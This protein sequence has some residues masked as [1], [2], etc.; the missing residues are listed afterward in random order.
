M[1]KTYRVLIVEDESATIELYQNA[2]THVQQQSDT[3]EFQIETAKDCPTAYDNICKAINGIPYDLVFLDISLPSSNGH[4]IKS[5]EDLGVLIRKKM[6][7]TRIIVITHH[8]E[9]FI[10]NRVYISIRPDSFVVKSDIDGINDLYLMIE[11]VIDHNNFFSRRVQ[12]LMKQQLASK[13]I[14]DDLDVSILLEIMNGSK[15]KELIEEIPLGD[16][17]ITKR[18]V[19]IKQKFG[20][21]AMSDRSMILYAKE[22]GF[23]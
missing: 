19:V 14:L 9:P 12:M 2:L 5:G 7:S 23:I 13:D 20:D 6:S 8:F 1:T 11:K 3:I 21:R 15:M 4:A 16:S 10:L 22:H 18:K 17:A